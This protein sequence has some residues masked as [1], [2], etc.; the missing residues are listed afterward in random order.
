MVC[1]WTLPRLFSYSAMLL[2]SSKLFSR[3]NSSSLMVIASQLSYARTILR[4]FDDIPM[5]KYNLDCM[6]PSS[7]RSNIIISEDFTE[8][9]LIRI[10]NLVDQLYYPAEHMVSTSQSS[11]RITSPINTPFF[12]SIIIFKIASIYNN[13]Y[14]SKYNI[15]TC[16][17]N[18]EYTYE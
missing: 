10:I 5:L 6:K 4:L 16:K 18:Y 11:Q 12:R 2:G 8:S 1:E 14:N 3:T 9:L 15:G 7:S 17:Q 13:L